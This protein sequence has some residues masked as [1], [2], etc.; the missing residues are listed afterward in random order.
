MGFWVRAGAPSQN[1]IDNTPD[2]F[3]E[4]PLLFTAPEAQAVN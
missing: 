1:I 3:P 2:N 4:E